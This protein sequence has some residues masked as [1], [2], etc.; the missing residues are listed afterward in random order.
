MR[1]FGIVSGLVLAGVLFA[2]PTASAFD[3]DDGGSSFGSPSESGF[4]VPRTLD[5]KPP[6]PA[7]PGTYWVLVIELSGCGVGTI[8]PAGAPGDGLLYEQTCTVRRVW[9]LKKK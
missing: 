5:A 3:L 7:P 6:F 2:G 1:R 4:F 9:K 8:T